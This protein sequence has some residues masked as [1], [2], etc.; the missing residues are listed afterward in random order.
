MDS[1]PGQTWTWLIAGLGLVLGLQGAVAWLRRLVRR[2][3]VLRRARDA[4]AGERDAASL[5]HSL[6]YRV[7]E[8]QPRA[9]LSLRV[10][11]RPVEVELRADYLVQA[12][13]TRLVAEVKTGALAP[14]I[15]TA[16]TRRQLLEYRL[17]Y[18][19]DGA[20]LVD[21]ETGRTQRV[22]F[23]LKR[24]QSSQKFLWLATGAALGL[25]LGVRLAGYI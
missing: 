1:W 7:L 18:G 19:V 23:P 2:S 17:A 12:G 14:N 15:R 20:L 3:R 5:L 16:A 11:G 22:D 25:W 9:Q 4:Q 13:S 21:M 10:D 8:A 24:A 6:G